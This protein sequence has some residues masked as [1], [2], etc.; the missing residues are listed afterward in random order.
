MHCNDQ[1]DKYQRSIFRTIYVFFLC[2]AFTSPAVSFGKVKKPLLGQVSAQDTQKPPPVFVGIGYG[3]PPYIFE[4]THQGFF[5]DIIDRAFKNVGREVRYVY[6]PTRRLLRFEGLDKIDAIGGAPMVNK[7][8]CQSTRF[9]Q[10]Q[11]VVIYGRDVP[12]IKTLD[13][14]KKHSL[15]AFQNAKII[16]GPDYRKAVSRSPNYYEMINQRSQVRVFLKGRFDAAVMDRNIFQYWMNHFRDTEGLIRSYKIAR[17]FNWETNM[18]L[19]FKDPDICNQFNRGLAQ[20]KQAGL[21]A[22]L[23]SKYRMLD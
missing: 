7:D 19:E 17:L 14:L 21:I 4:E 2:L 8:H 18:G 15:A 13:D 23:R 16:L 11:N 20:M 10:F 22:K 1:H 5:L 6:L 12:D 9:M 3:K